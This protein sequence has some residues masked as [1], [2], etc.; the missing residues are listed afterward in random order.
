[1][2]GF[3]RFENRTR[4]TAALLMETALSV[5]SRASL[6]PTDSDLPVMRTP[7]GLPFIPGSSIKGALRAHAERI[8]RSLPPDLGF[9]AC[10]PFE[11][12][13]ISDSDKRR[14]LRAAGGRESA[15]AQSIWDHSCTI[16]RLFGSPW[17]SSRLFFKDAFLTNA[18]NLPILTQVRDGVGIDRDLGAARTNV[19]YDFETVVPGSEFGIEILGENLE[20]WEVGLLLSV[21]HTWEEG[22]LPIGGK[23]TRGLGWGKLGIQKI[24]RVEQADLLAYLLNQV[25]QQKSAADFETE[26]RKEITERQGEAQAKNGGESHA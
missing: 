4:I 12:P 22:S 11:K 1:M 5:G 23:S 20:A 3:D 10:D 17:F 25:M 18:A 21:L 7:D 14:F 2:A 9:E 8:L 15:F 26:L 19:K 24:E 13:C 6:N 16:C